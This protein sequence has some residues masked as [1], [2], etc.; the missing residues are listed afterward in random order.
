MN[1]ANFFS[2]FTIIVIYKICCNLSF[3]H[4][5]EIDRWWVSYLFLLSH[6]NRKCELVPHSFV[7]H[8]Y[9]NCPNPFV[10]FFYSLL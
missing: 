10:I 5:I 4:I 8:Y 1:Y 2:L 9:R 6:Y 3:S 7:T